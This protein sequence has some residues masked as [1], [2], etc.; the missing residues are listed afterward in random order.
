[1]TSQTKAE[2]LKDMRT[3]A[4]QRQKY[5]WKTKRR[6]DKEA[7]QAY[8]KEHKYCEVCL[9]EGRGGFNAV[10]THEILY[11]SQGGKCEESNMLSVCRN[12]HMRCHFLKAEWLYRD[13][14]YEMKGG[15]QD[16]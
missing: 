12:D 16:D 3:F 4:K 9:A 11:R 6:K 8:W 5:N 13:D 14:L 10:E 1:M 7:Q 2:W 15:K